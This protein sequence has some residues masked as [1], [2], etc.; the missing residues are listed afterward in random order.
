M[1]CMYVYSPGEW[2]ARKQGLPTLTTPFQTEEEAELF[3]EIL[4]A[5]ENSRGGVD[6][7][8]L[9]HEFNRRVMETPA[10]MAKV[11]LKTTKYVKDFCKKLK[12]R[13]LLKKSC[14]GWLDHLM[15]VR[16]AHRDDSYSRW[17]PALQMQQQAAPVPVAAP[18]A[19]AA[20]AAGA[21]VADASVKPI[22][23]KTC[24]LCKLKKQ[25][26][27]QIEMLHSDVRNKEDKYKKHSK[28][29]WCPV[30]GTFTGKGRC[31]LCH[32]FRH[33]DS[34]HH[35]PDGYCLHEKAYPGTRSLRNEHGS[36]AP[37]TQD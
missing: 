31:S 1:T 21:A 12:Q 2:L 27:V 25:D 13:M 23:V 32:R 19:P 15:D 24:T 11:G 37:P 14:T 9:A 28:Y 34:A 17:T 36:G 4:P 29:G 16:R 30:K 26:K 10:L 35:D 33:E 3:L 5:F 22:K 6:E 7:E 20:A 18:I 8:A